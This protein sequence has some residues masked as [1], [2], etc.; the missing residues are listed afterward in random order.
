MGFLTGKRILILGIISKKSIAYGIAQAM[1]K[2]GA[3]LAITYQNVRFK[4]RVEQLAAE[5]GSEL[6]LP[7]DVSI[8]EEITTLFTDLKKS[9][10]H[11]DG[12]VHA[13]GF[14][15][16]DQLDGDYLDCV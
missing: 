16:A 15:P 1:H 12:I 4:D 13:I 10:D 11:I 2:Q 3:E 9:W 6:V 7:C 8:D 14:A 5:C